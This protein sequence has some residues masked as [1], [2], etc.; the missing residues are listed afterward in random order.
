MKCKLHLCVGRDRIPAV[1][2]ALAESALALMPYTR[3]LRRYK[4]RRKVDDYFLKADI[5]E[6]SRD[7]AFH[8]EI[9]Q[10]ASESTPDAAAAALD[11][12]KTH[13]R[14]LVKE[15][16]RRVCHFDTWVKER[17]EY[18]TEGYDSECS[19]D[20]DDVRCT[21]QF[22]WCWKCDSE[23]KGKRQWAVSEVS[24]VRA[25]TL[26]HSHALSRPSHAFRMRSHSFLHCFA[27]Q[28]CGI[29]IGVLGIRFPP[30]SKSYLGVK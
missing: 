20:S 12:Y 1:Y 7:L 9:G 10:A 17:A 25:R 28:R 30:P 3:L 29:G 22:E 23:G 19:Y 24:E 2:P 27:R 4:G 26:T 5:A 8:S 11:D 15:I 16:N 13:R 14:A 6:V 21:S 18:G